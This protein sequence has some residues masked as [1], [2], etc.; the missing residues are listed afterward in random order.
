MR[1]WP[2]THTPCV[3]ARETATRRSTE[4]FTHAALRVVETLAVFTA[5]AA[6]PRAAYV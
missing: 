4:A 3:A 5:S 1:Y 2:F 6:Q